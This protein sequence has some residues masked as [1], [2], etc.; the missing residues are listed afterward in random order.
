VRQPQ[1]YTIVTGPGPG[2]GERDTFTCA[3]CNRVKVVKPMMRAEDMGG[4]CHL[5]G[6]KNRPSFICELCL[7]KGCDPFEKKMK[8][9]EARDRLIREMRCS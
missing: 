5:C 7:G 8:R 6:D 2:A 1:G 4:I 3:H 9:W